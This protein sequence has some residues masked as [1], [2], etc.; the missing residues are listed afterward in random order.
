MKRV[1]GTQDDVLFCIRLLNIH[2]LIGVRLNKYKRIRTG[3]FI[4]CIAKSVDGIGGVLKRSLTN[5][6]TV[7]AIE[8]KG[9]YNDLRAAG[10][11]STIKT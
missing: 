9:N 2:C 1:I 7:N 8:L 5:V 11:G 3:I 6:Q 10:T 4:I